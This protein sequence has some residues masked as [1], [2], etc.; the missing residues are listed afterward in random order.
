MIIF[1]LSIQFYNNIGL[2]ATFNNAN[3]WFFT[4]IEILVIVRY[5]NHRLRRYLEY[6]E[7]KILIF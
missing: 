6:I 1:P 7:I 4:F 3:K 2:H 5:I